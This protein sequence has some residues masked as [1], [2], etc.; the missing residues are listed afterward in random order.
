MYSAML[1]C[2]AKLHI[3]VPSDIGFKN[4]WGVFRVKNVF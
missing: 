2:S 1:L 4:E 3:L